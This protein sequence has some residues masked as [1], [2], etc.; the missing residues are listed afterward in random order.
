MKNIV[1]I[2]TDTYRY[3]NLGERAARQVRTRELDRFAAER[4]TAIEG[5]YTGSFPTIPHRTDVATGTLGWPHYGWQAID[6]CGP[7]HVAKMLR[8]CGYASQLIC[9]CPHLFNARYQQGFDAAFQHRGQEGD[10][11][12]LRLNTPIRSVM[13]DAKTRTEPMFRGHNLPD[14]HRWMNR[15]YEVEEEDLPVANGRHRGP[16][17]RRERPD[18]PVFPVGWISLIPTS[19]GTP[20]NTL[21]GD[22]TRIT[23]A[24]RC[25]I[26]IT[27][28][29]QPIRQTSSITSGRTMRPRRS[30]LI[31]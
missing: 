22:T 16:L 18:R 11:H 28:Q 23:P 30:W 4:A 29:R 17:A 2:I 25:F 6:L 31:A 7:N 5:F 27:G 15:D 3:D 8:E 21:C 12:L 1:L 14:C 9:D 26:P 19:H 10:K 20:R 24:P 13:A